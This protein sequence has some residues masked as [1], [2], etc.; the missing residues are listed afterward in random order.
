M[1]LFGD[2]GVDRI[3]LQLGRGQVVKQDREHDGLRLACDGV[4]E[5][6]VDLQRSAHVVDASV[7]AHAEPGVHVSRI[8]GLG[9]GADANLTQVPPLD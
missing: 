3:D 8:H 5:T 4:A 1:V 2:H 9:V 7:Q 6:H